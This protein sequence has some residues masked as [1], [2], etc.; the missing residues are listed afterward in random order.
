MV[1]HDLFPHPG[2]LPDSDSFRRVRD[3]RRTAFHL[4]TGWQG[5]SCEKRPRSASYLAVRGRKPQY[6]NSTKDGIDSL[7]TATADR[8]I[9]QRQDDRWMFVG[10]PAGIH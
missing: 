1:E 10:F 6:S 3:L 2:R 5:L 7:W 9:T 4:S 8:P